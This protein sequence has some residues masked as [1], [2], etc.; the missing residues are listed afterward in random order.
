MKT[1]EYV[2]LL[3]GWGGVQ[4][5][6]HTDLLRGQGCVVEPQVAHG[7]GVGSRRDVAPVRGFA[8]DCGTDVALIGLRDALCGQSPVDPNLLMRAGELKGQVCPHARLDA[9]RRA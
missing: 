5:G 2:W 1:S 6:Q 8:D 3:C 7:S 4:A 9:L